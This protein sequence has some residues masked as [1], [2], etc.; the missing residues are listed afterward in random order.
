V[1]GQGSEAV[2]V[3]AMKRGARD[4]LVKGQI[5]PRSLWR[6]IQHAVA[7]TELRTQLALSARVLEE[8]NIELERLNDVISR[9]EARFRQVVEAAPNAMVMIN[10]DS[11]I[12]LVNSLT[13]QLFG[14]TR[15]E[16][17][18]APIEMLVPERLRAR[19]SQLRQQFLADKTSGHKT[20]GRALL[21]LRKDGREIELEI[22]LNHIETEDGM[23]VL[24]AIVDISARVRLESELRQAQKM[25]I[26]GRLSA[27]VGHDFNNI[28]QVI[29]GGVD[30]LLVEPA[31]PATAGIYVSQIENAAKRA[32]SLT[33]QLLAYSRK[34][35]LTLKLVDLEVTLQR[36]GEVLTRTLASNIALRIEKMATP[37]RVRTDPGQLETALM[38]LAINAA[39]AMPDGGSLSFPAAPSSSKVSHPANTPSFRWSIPASA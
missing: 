26:L 15:S 6:V 29:F 18:G 2:A 4:Y 12:V 14:Y 27:G 22:A 31:L 33:H 17:L 19:H 36:L 32:Q 20:S 38:N 30:G 9:S 25:Q 16:L 23:M 13:E 8:R 5:G 3:E 37:A 34:Q 28:L 7:E 39:H 10:P 1:T 11:E 35:M 24:S 21:G